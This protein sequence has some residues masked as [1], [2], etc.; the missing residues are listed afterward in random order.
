MDSVVVEELRQLLQQKPS[1]PGVVALLQ[2]S[3]E[4]ALALLRVIDALESEVESLTHQLLDS[5]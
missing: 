4:E 2:L 5:R 3:R 1:E